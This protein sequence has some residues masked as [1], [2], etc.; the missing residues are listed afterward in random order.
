MTKVENMTSTQFYGSGVYIIAYENMFCEEERER[1]Y[2]ETE[3][4]FQEILLNKRL[5]ANFVEVFPKVF[6][7]YYGIGFPGDDH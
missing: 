5:S 6:A 2:I 4:E 3:Q 1:V 7:V